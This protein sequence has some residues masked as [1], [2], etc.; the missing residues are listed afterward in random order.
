[1]K[2]KTKYSKIGPRTF[3]DFTKNKQITKQT[4]AKQKQ[5]KKQKQKTKQNKRNHLSATCIL[6]AR[7]S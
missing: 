7:I 3:K 2:Q 5:Q 1:M 4:K 6:L